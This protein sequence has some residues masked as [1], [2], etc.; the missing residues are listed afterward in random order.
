[1][2]AREQMIHL[3]RWS[4]WNDIQ[5]E[6]LELAAII[7]AG[8]AAGKTVADILSECAAIEPD[9]DIL[10]GAGMAIEYLREEEFQAILRRARETEAEPDGAR[11]SLPD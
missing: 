1:M 2:D 6:S 10:D 4:A 3:L 9:R 7:R 8:V 11:N 5:S